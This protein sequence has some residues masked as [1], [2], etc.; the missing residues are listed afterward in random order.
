MLLTL[1]V[2]CV[3]TAHIC[4]AETLQNLVE[5]AMAL[6]FILEIDDFM[7]RFLLTPATKRFFRN[8]VPT[9]TLLGRHKDK[10]DEAPLSAY[11][12]R[13]FYGERHTNGIRSVFGNNGWILL[14]LVLGAVWVCAAMYGLPTALPSWIDWLGLGNWTMPVGAGLPIFLADVVLDMG[15]CSASPAKEKGD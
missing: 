10:R 7:Y 14:R 12:G 2:L 15:V 11:L 8:S 5:N 6:L 3:G 9:I 13:H 4:R 1:Y